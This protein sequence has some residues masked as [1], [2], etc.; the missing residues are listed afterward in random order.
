MF[1]S[2]VP[3]ATSRRRSAIRAAETCSK[4][5]WFDTARDCGG[6]LRQRVSWDRCL[7]FLFKHISRS[8][9]GQDL[10]DIMIGKAQARV[11]N[12]SR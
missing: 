3:C 8:Y 10:G 1:Y 4:R 6:M 5:E 7:C 12:S 2:M 9:I 11:R